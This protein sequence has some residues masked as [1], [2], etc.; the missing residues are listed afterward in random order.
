MCI[1]PCHRRAIKDAAY[2]LATA[3]ALPPT[4]PFSNTLTAGRSIPGMQLKASRSI[5]LNVSFFNI[6]FVQAHGLFWRNPFTASPEKCRCAELVDAAVLL[7][8][9]ASMHAVG[10]SLLGAQELGLKMLDWM[11]ARGWDD[12]HG[13][14]FYFRLYKHPRV[15]GMK[16]QCV[17]KSF[18]IVCVPQGRARQTSTRVSCIGR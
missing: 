18:D 6:L 14:L 15:S 4:A 7:A 2:L 3:D 13:G 9:H 16:Y 1:T 8:T 17:P 10:Y 12:V 11:W 5:S